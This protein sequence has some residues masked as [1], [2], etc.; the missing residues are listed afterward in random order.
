[1]SAGPERHV[2]GAVNALVRRL[3]TRST[4]PDAM[5]AIC[6]SCPSRD[7]R[8][9]HQAQ[10]DAGIDTSHERNVCVGCRQSFYKQLLRL[11]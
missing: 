5:K 4:E 3:S 11:R 1:M 7:A 9:G 2:L 6:A 8:D 10:R